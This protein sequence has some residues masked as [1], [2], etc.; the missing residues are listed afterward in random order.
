M[1]STIE[2][3][4]AAIDTVG[5]GGWSAAT[6]ARIAERA[7]ISQKSFEEAF[8]TPMDWVPRAFDRL[9]QRRLEQ[10]ERVAASTAQ[11]GLD[12]EV[13]VKAALE[14]VLDGDQVDPLF[15]ATLDLFFMARDK[16]ELMREIRA[17]RERRS[18]DFRRAEARLFPD[19][20]PAATQQLVM[21]HVG[22]IGAIAIATGFDS[23]DVRASNVP[24]LAK[25]LLG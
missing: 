25:L 18:A 10:Y 9:L 4:D 20:T 19:G 2:I 21:T 5:D 16:P 12:P 1:K 13:N 8:A 3:L 7:G 14:T 15:A 11:E 22:F 23:F 24:I 17:I 6:N